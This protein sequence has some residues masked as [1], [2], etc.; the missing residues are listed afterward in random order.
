M[1]YI[2]LNQVMI[3]NIMIEV[4]RAKN[5]VD[6]KLDEKIIR[7]MV[8]NSLRSYIVK[9]KKD[10]GEVVIACD[11]T[12][13]WRKDFFPQYK[14]NRKK[15]R[16]ENP[17]VDWFLIFQTLNKIRAEL[18]EYFPYKVIEVSTA[19]ADD[20]IAVLATEIKEK[21][22]ILSSDKD[23][24]QLQ[25]FDH[26][27]QYSPILDRNISTENPVTFLNELILRGDRGDGVPNFLSDDN[28]FLE[29]T[30]QKPISAKN[31]EKWVHESPGTFCTNETMRR[32]YARNRTLIDLTCIPVDLQDN[33]K[34]AYAEATKGKATNLLNYFIENNLTVLINRIQEFY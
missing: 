19:E 25:K 31:L 20:I 27:K 16:Q 22:M 5:A 12:K 7:H 30:R 15:D 3:S 32:G 4:N 33:I 9:F 11:S 2:D 26:I 10:Y 13:S 28:C 29:N 6:K 14:A 1:L 24:V 17:D 8:L 23:F 18:K 21:S 34:K